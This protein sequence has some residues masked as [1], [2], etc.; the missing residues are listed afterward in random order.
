MGPEDTRKYWPAW[1]ERPDG[2]CLRW[3][4]YW[5]DR[6]G[7][8]WHRVAML[9]KNWLRKA[10]ASGDLLLESVCLARLSIC[11]GSE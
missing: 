1:R 5:L 9:S 11:S 4:L 6:V 7:E 3:R 10:L 2:T 8:G